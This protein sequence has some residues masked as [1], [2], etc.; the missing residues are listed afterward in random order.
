MLSQDDQVALFQ[1]ARDAIQA[2]LLRLPPPDVPTGGAEL[3]EVRGVFVTLRRRDDG[4]L[5]GCIGHTIGQLPLA[6]GVRT[7]AVSAA[8]HDRRFAPVVTSELAGLHVELSVLSP[9]EAADPAGIEIGRHGLMIR[10]NARAGLL[11]P[12]VASE[13]GWDPETF[14]RHTCLKAGLPE[15][16][17]RE[18]DAELRW[19]SCEIYEEPE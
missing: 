6:E 14:L 3:G 5:R 15:D 13:R 9:L 1:L 8:L 7:L 12:Q 4:A 19:F 10:K 18:S 17:W 11:L 16:A 2:A